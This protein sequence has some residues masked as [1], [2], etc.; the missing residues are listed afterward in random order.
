MRA[1]VPK[2]M[3]LVALVL[4]LATAAWGLE[5][6][7]LGSLV[8]T[9]G[10]EN[11]DALRWLYEIGGLQTLTE[12]TNLR[13]RLSV[14]YLSLLEGG[15]SDLWSTRFYGQLRA[16]SYRADAQFTPWQRN[17]LGVQNSRERQAQAAFHLTPRGAPQ[18]DVDWTRLDRELAAGNSMSDTKR[19]QVSYGLR[20]VQGEVGYRRIDTTAPGIAAATATDEWHGRLQGQ[21]G[22]HRGTVTGSY[23]GLLSN[24]RARER[25]RELET[26]GVSLGASYAPLTKLTL[27]GS[28]LRRWGGIDDNGLIETREI[29]ELTLSGNA[30]YRPTRDLE[31]QATREYRRG[32]APASGFT[33]DYLQLEALFRRAILPGFLFQT[34]Y[35]GVL[36]FGAGGD[37]PNNGAYVLVDGRLRNGIEARGELRAARP[38]SAGTSGTQWR[39]MLQLRARPNEPTHVEVSWRRDTMAEYFGTQQTDR[40]WFLLAGYEPVHMASLVFAWRALDGWGRVQRS[41]RQTTLTGNWNPSERST[42]S[43]N[44]SHRTSWAGFATSID[45]VLGIDLTF[46]LPDEVQARGSYRRAE[47]VAN[48]ERHSYG[49]TLEK[50]F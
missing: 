26:H 12:D 5:G 20:D 43:A 15:D 25:R 39:R 49:L 18:I 24:Y 48:V 42:L 30:A 32:S 2:M 17:L 31:V 44:W 14:N 7:T 34:G 13:L 35:L 8:H 4:L 37:V 19:M 40:E 29:D 38:Q 9:D 47:D 45:D 50:R 3:A 28:A 41:E 33:S 27:G 36:D 23:E 6:R 22:F 16:P 1:A 11:S 21:R 10:V 46:W